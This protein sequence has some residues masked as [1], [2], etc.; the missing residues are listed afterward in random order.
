MRALVIGG[1]GQ[2]GAALSACLSARGHSVIGTHAQT[3]APA[4]RRLDFTDA[5]ATKR[6]IAE[7]TP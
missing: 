3:A 2:V 4:T 1:S 7:T 6:L 5:V